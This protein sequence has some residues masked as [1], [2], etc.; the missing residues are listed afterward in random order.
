MLTLS[1]RSIFD[2]FEI[3]QTYFYILCMLYL[4]IVKM[5]FLQY[6]LRYQKTSFFYKFGVILL[7]AYVSCIFLSRL[8]HDDGLLILTYWSIWTY[9]IVHWR[10]W[11]T[12]PIVPR[13]FYRFE[14][15]I[16]LQPSFNS[17]DVECSR[18]WG[19]FY[20]VKCDTIK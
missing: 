7:S 14:I 1:L 10:R 15:A 13:F 8:Q 9:F 20:I 5:Y 4:I 3:L 6:S 19:L 2:N 18:F 11:A 12:V 16:V 17:F